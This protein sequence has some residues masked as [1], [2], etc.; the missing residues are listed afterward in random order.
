MLE[1]NKRPVWVEIY[2][3]NI[4]YNYNKIEENVSRETLIMAVI[5]A[6]AYGHGIESLADSL[7]ESGC[8]RFGVAFPEEG[9][10]IRELGFSIP[11]HVLGE[12]LPEQISK[13]IEYDLIPTV[14]K[15][16]TIR[17]L[18]T[19]A[20]KKGIKK[21]VH[22]KIDTGM[23]RIGVKPHKALEFISKIKNNYSNI[24]IEGLISHFANADSKNKEYTYKQWEKFNNLIKQL[25]KE[26][27]HIPIKHIAN[28]AAVID[29]PEMEL[30]MI[31][32]G[33]MLYGLKPSSQVKDI[34]LKPALTWKTKVVYLK[35]VSADTGISY[36]LTYKTNKKTKVA[37][38]P[39]GYADGYSRLLSNKA[40]VLIK[41]KRAPIIGNVCMDQ[42][43]V[44]VT[45]IPVEI[46]DEVILIGEQN[47]E[48]ISA[49]ELANIMGT[50]NYEVI[51]SI[52]E[53]VPR[54][55]I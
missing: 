23:G 12:V 7:I 38:L 31:R 13:I 1:Y 45:D 21:K 35:E 50:I 17:N 55:Y 4:K 51:C 9:K 41:G 26:D 53:R 25:D 49:S 48:K 44:D 42:F 8:D 22:I 27:I 10:E 46:G 16:E 5:K 11:I 29:L 32:P 18:N 24:Y 36:G 33:I 14:S 6:K 43:M 34:S 47:H 54:L 3:D 30:D 52:S 39:L 40:E 37:T 20:K 2:L 28:S 19:C 15:E